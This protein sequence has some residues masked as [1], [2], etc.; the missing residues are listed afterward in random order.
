LDESALCRRARWPCGAAT[1]RK[2]RGRVSAGGART[3]TVV[4][5]FRRACSNLPPHLQLPQRIPEI[6]ILLQKRLIPLEPPEQP[7]IDRQIQHRFPI[8]HPGPPL[9]RNRHLLRELLVRIMRF[10]LFIIGRD[11]LHRPRLQARL[12]RLFLQPRRRQR[13]QAPI[14]I[15]ATHIGVRADEPALLDGQVRRPWRR[16]RAAGP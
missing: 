2:Q 13:L 5:L 6:R 1:T 10:A 11:P 4:R 16:T 12:P 3:S 15:S 8:P 9:H 7:I 14:L